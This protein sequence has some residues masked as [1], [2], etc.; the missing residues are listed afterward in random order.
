MESDEIVSEETFFPDRKSSDEDL[1]G[2]ETE[3]I[4]I[5][6]KRKISSNLKV[7][8]KNVIP[9]DDQVVP[10]YHKD[11]VPR[12]KIRLDSSIA[13][14]RSYDANE[15][16]KCDKVKE[17]EIESIKTDSDSIVFMPLD[18]DSEISSS[19]EDNEDDF[20]FEVLGG[21]GDIIFYPD[22][23]DVEEECL[24]YYERT[25]TIFYFGE[26]SDTEE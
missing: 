14:E 2:K 21:R 10:E 17:T 26:S 16:E 23:S 25:M 9:Q 5:S 24:T 7:K 4:T 15:E 20:A 6:R 12:T 18:T 13:R 3:Q 19:D 8:D 11:D 1:S 22:S